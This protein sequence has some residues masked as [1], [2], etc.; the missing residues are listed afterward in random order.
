MSGIAAAALKAL[1]HP[2][3]VYMSFSF[4]YLSNYEAANNPLECQNSRFLR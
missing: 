1:L 4:F 3:E 2:E